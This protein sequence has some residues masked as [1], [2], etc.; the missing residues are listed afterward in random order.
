MK[1]ARKPGTTSRT[2]RRQPKPPRLSVGLTPRELS[3]LMALKDRHQVSMAWLGRQAILEFIEKYT[4]EHLQLPLRLT[5]R[6][7]EPQ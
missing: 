5:Q 3:E 7:G 1:V 4:N 6:T 2:N